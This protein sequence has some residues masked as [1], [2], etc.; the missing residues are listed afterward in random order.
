MKKLYIVDAVNYLFRSYYAI[1]PMTNHK[2]ES[3]S[4]LYGFIRSIQKI[5]KDFDVENMVAVFDGPD[6]KSSRLAVYAEYKMNR[7]GAPEDL[8]SQFE[9]AYE[10]CRFSGI[11]TL[12]VDKVEADDTIASVANWAKNEGFE[13][14]ICSSDKDLF[15]LVTNNVFILLAHKD[16]SI[17]NAKKVEEI[18]GVTPSQMLDFLAIMGDTSDNIPGLSGFGP[19]T[20]ASLL[21]QFKTLDYILEHPNEVPGKK[22]QETLIEQKD[23]AL[24]SR[25]LAKLDIEIKI[26]KD[27]NFYTIKEKN[28]ES[29]INLFENMK[30][31]SLLKE[32]G[33][34]KKEVLLPL[35]KEPEEIKYLLV[36][37]EP[38]LNELILQLSQAKEIC[39]D[40]ETTK[41]SPQDANLVGIGLSTEAGS[42]W[43]I[44]FNAKLTKE[45]II[46]KLTSIFENPTIGFFGH[47][48]KYDYHILKKYGLEIK[49][50]SFDTMIASYLLN[51]QNRRHNLDLLALEIIRKHKIPIKALIG[52]GKK[53]ISMNEVDINSV[54]EYCSED[55]D[56]TYRLKNYF[57][58]KIEE[59]NLSP[60]LEE[61]E[62]PLIFV[63]AKMEQKG[64]YLDAK[65]LRQMQKSLLVQ[66]D[67]IKSQIFK[68]VGEEFNLNSPKQ[69]SEILYTRLNLTPPSRKKTEYST[70]A[71]VLE[72]LAEESIVASKI[73]EYRA[74]EKLRSTYV[75]ALPNQI[76][77]K[78]N[79]IHCTFNQSVTATGRLSCQ[80]PNLQ[81]IPIKSD[82]GRQI[83]IGFKPQLENWSFLSADYSQIELRLL[84]HFSK[85]LELI[86]AF[87]ENQDIHAYTASLVFNV[88]ITE[89]TKDMRYLA[90]A[91]NFGILYGQGPFGLSQEIGISMREASN[92][93][94][95]YFAR[96]PKVSE[97]ISDCKKLVKEKKY[98]TTL[99]GRKRPIHEIDNKN[100]VIRAAAERLAV[101]T[102]LQGTAAD[103]IKIAMIRIDNEIKKM[104]LQGYMILQI[105]DE[106]IFEI[107]NEELEIFQPMVKKIMESALSLDVPLLVDVKIGKNWAEC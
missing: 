69:L 75:E 34:A 58:L 88:P 1:G 28:S 86:K 22:K 76:S 91:V 24:M 10:Y 90:K 107:P 104:N 92:F 101:N 102:P 14:Y 94:K 71:K 68:E 15:Q 87:K 82:Q 8:F 23:V 54:K 103:L 79:R 7:K 98:A 78:T 17:V 12:C 77:K 43:Y 99:I 106:L 66:I 29:L 9:W 55:V 5:I 80:N 30:F 95:T 38:K 4:A 63:L 35:I 13:V 32:I 72:M 37:T 93:I 27:L 57:K 100:P 64:I 39:I 26:P 89:V 60:L 83:R 84:A 6:N 3:T 62:I 50:I 19:K 97:Y 53:Q 41:L 65:K 36:E 21:K 73:L 52:E 81:N 105:H 74:L 20:A 33:P 49:N 51:P 11:S 56:Y 40:T 67:K 47:N 25:E 18:Y 16:N 46:K 42:A 45:L 70:G 2:G 96:Y 85:D 61:I 48:I 31:T 59:N 44:P